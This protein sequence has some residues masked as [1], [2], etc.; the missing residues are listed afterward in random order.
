MS[1]EPP[2]KVEKI[3]TDLVAKV[4]V[5]RV[6]SL[7]QL[8]PGWSSERFNEVLGFVLNRKL[9]PLMVT[10]WCSVLRLR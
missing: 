8:N 4:C 5:A 3:A 6:L 10:V 1:S 7:A 2:S 9:W